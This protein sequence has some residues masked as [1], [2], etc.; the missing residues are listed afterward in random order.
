[1]HSF[2]YVLVLQ[3]CAA[4]VFVN[5]NGSSVFA[6][7]PLEIPGELESEAGCYFTTD[8]LRGQSYIL[9]RNFDRSPWLGL[10]S[11]PIKL[12]V[13]REDYPQE[14]GGPGVLEYVAP[15]VTVRVDLRAP[16]ECKDPDDD[17]LNSEM[18]GVLEVRAGDASQ[19]IRV[20]GSC[21]C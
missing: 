21:G 6:P 20:L 5:I 9:G 11:G 10:K 12:T 17:C 4:P 18:T 1:M 13:V 16:K 2:L 8:D 7:L 19:R 14:L 3:S 15:G